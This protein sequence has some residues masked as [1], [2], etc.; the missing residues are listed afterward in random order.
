MDVL[1][2]PSPPPRRQRPRYVEGLKAAAARVEEAD[3]DRLVRRMLAAYGLAE[4]YEWYQAITVGKVVFDVDGKGTQ[5]TP[6]AL[7]AAALAGVAAFFGFMPDRVLIASS[8][9][10]DKLSYRLFVPGY[11]MQMADIKRRLVRLGLDQNRP[12]DSAIYGTNQKLRM[13]GSIKTKQ[14][15]RPLKLVDANG[16]DIP[17]TAELLMDTLVQVVDDGWPLLTEPVEGPA[18]KRKCTM[19]TPAEASVQSRVRPSDITSGSDSD[20]EVPEDAPTFTRPSQ[21]EASALLTEAGFRDV[22]FVLRFSRKN[23]LRF[24]ADRT[25]PCVCCNNQHDRNGWWCARRPD[26]RLCVRSYSE[27]CRPLIL[28]ESR[29]AVPPEEV[30]AI[31][32]Q[33][34]A[35][36]SN[37]ITSTGAALSSMVVGLLSDDRR[38]LE[39][40][41]KD[42][43]DLGTLAHVAGDRFSCA[44]AAGGKFEFENVI[45]HCYAV[46]QVV[47]RNG[48]TTLVGVQEA[49]LLREL[50]HMPSADGLYA[51]WLAEDQRLR[52]VAWK[53]DLDDH[54]YRSTGGL[55]E[56]VPP[57]LI[58][59]DFHNMAV[60]KLQLLLSVCDAHGADK[61]AKDLAK[62]VRSVVK[63][64]EQARSGTHM[65]VLARQM[66]LDRGFHDTL[67]RATGVLGTPS[68]VL[69]LRTGHVL[70]SADRPHVSMS[71][72]PR[73][74][75]LDAPTPD[76]DAFFLSIFAGNHETV[77]YVRRLLGAA[78]TGEQLEAYVCL[79]GV[80]S[81][82]KSV[83]LTWLRHVLKDYH[84]SADSYIFFADARH[85]NNA[86]PALAAL[87]FKRFAVV[88]ES[89]PTDPL[90][91]AIVKRLTGT[92][93]ITA[94]ELYQ[95]PRDIPL[96]HTQFLATNELPRIDV[97][98]EAM[99]RRVIVLPFGIRFK[100]PED[101][102][103][104]DPTQRLSDPTMGA[105]L[106]S[107]GA[108][109]QLLSWLVHGAVDFYAAGQRL[110]PKP[111]AVRA[112][113]A[114]YTADNDPIGAL[115]AEEC[116]MVEGARV[117]CQEFNE[118]ATARGAKRGVK[119]AM[120][121]RGFL[122]RTQTVNGRAGVQCY[123]GLE[124]KTMN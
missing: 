103:A 112:A 9:G 11:R 54:L 27:H 18:R 123:V 34:Q 6:A 31:Q 124:W 7:L 40:A 104:T 105:F 100:Q 24:S 61:H 111:T 22:E 50:M 17:P 95:G 102:D 33:I 76:V 78:L 47:P 122:R 36:L 86:T 58:V 52:G 121:R 96:T 57:T 10:G 62:G 88:E 93:V 68:G 84:L 91:K 12:F 75:G 1:P 98:D 29:L 26:G 81:N 107:D 55:W 80:G 114:A 23:S 43:M 45:Q 101:Y 109:E 38:L 44:C 90:N 70:T 77:A 83:T 49:R 117:V 15:R 3:A 99:M 8:H 13:V 71:V 79:V 35:V 16:A 46:T 106:Q 92:R 20:D 74:I 60:A 72:R 5:S 25:H 94:R 108:S 82:G 19:T 87:E 32:G 21:E 41:L 56:R 119:N 118:R 69:D 53:A 14:D 113:E 42:R 66:F 4:L 37:A 67:N 115:I 73:W 30:L 59:S 51:R 89:Q 48:G 110:L 97:D 64:V 63:H 28:G 2:S 65:L 120:E 39:E 85:N 116:Q